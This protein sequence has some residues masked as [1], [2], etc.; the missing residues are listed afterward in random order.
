MPITTKTVSGERY[1]YFSHY[2]N[3][4]KKETYC[5]LASKPE[6]KR[7]AVDLEIISLKEQRKTIL[8]KIRKLEVQRHL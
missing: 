2:K 4:K 8:D 1:I 6:S 5:G 3:G 7:K